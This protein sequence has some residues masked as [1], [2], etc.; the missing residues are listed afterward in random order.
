[1]TI[2]AF[3]KSPLGIG[4]TLVALLAVLILLH[5]AFGSDVEKPKAETAAPT[6]T[7][8][9]LEAAKR[10]G[11]TMAAAGPAA[12]ETTVTLYGTVKP[13]AEREQELRARYP[14]IVRSVTKRPGDAVGAG[15]QVIT[16]EANSSLQSYG[17]KSPIAGRVLERQANPGESVGSDQILMKVADLRTVWAEFAVFA[18]DLGRIRAGMPIHISGAEGAKR[19][20]TTISYVAPSGSSDSQSVAARAV[21]LNANTEW[22]SGQFATA[23]VVVSQVDADVAVLPAAIQK[24]EGRSFVFVETEAGLVPREVTTGATSRDA[25]QI[26]S[27]LNAG[28][29]YAATNSYLIK[30]DLAKGEGEED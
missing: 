7:A 12:I 22:V 29:R 23:E 17:I 10:A 14:G 30:A 9:S 21:L 26:T 27:G 28:E 6:G 1:M 20:T 15:E 19:A 16:V 3:L 5:L 13:N 25:V 8:I 4:I 2:P 18:R 11:I 24:I